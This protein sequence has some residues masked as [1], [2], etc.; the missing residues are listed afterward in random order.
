MLDFN[1]FINDALL[2]LLTTKQQIMKKYLFIISLLI[3]NFINAQDTY[4]VNIDG[5]DVLVNVATDERIDVPE[6]DLNS[7][8]QILY[9]VQPG[10]TYYTIAKKNGMSLD[11]LYAINAIDKSN[12]LLVGTSLFLSKRKIAQVK[13][14]KQS[15]GYH[16]VQK[17]D[18]L[19][20][21]SRKHQVSVESILS[22]NNLTSNT[23]SVNQRLVIN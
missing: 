2:K 23:I 21:I 10:D 13:T 8:N 4:L 19:Y 15:S 14:T 18:T 9:K 11:D 5:K 22:N 3:Y 1:I 7:V 6:N 16:I 20:S 12:V 17:G